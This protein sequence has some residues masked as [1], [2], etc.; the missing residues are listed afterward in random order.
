MSA[1]QPGGD[2]ADL[3]TVVLALVGLAAV[4][5]VAGFVQGYLLGVTGER[6]VARLRSQLYARLVTLSLEFHAGRRVG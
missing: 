5:A 3:D 4:L 6:I 2:G 1:V